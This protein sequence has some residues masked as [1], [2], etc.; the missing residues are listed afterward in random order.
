[1][2]VSSLQTINGLLGQDKKTNSTNGKTVFEDFFNSAMNLVNQTNALE[3]EANQMSID[4]AAGKVDS[5]HDVMIAQEK[6][7]IALQYTVEI[8]NKVLEAYNEIMRIQL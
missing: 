2:N 7:N 1:M 6:A 8:R 3:K 5:I 4:F